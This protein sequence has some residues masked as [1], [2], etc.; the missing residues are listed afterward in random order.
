MKDLNLYYRKDY[1]MDVFIEDI[2]LSK[3]CT[4]KR[5]CQICKGQHPTV[6]HRQFPPRGKFKQGIKDNVNNSG[7]LVKMNDQKE[8]NKDDIAHITSA[9]GENDLHNL[10]KA[11][12]KE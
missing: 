4:K 12:P 9:D 10:V 7:N 3:E 1:V 8:D 5:T 2:Y 11:M 6:L